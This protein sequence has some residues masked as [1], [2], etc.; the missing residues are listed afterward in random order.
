MLAATR[1]AKH[2]DSA[3]ASSVQRSQGSFF[4]S[5]SNLVLCYWRLHHAEGGTRSLGVPQTAVSRIPLLFR[6]LLGE[7]ESHVSDGCLIQDSTLPDVLSVPLSCVLDVLG[8]R[9]TNS[10]HRGYLRPRHFP[11]QSSHP[12]S[13][14][15]MPQSCSVVLRPL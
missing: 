3:P 4:L 10:P 14:M 6:L 8:T 12:P 5:C 13:A 7:E 11:P 2:V 15:I 1:Q 9:D